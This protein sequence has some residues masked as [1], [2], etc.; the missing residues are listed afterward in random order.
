MRGSLLL[1]L[2]L[3]AAVAL[4]GTAAAKKKGKGRKK[5]P[6]AAEPLKCGVCHAA[7][8]QITEEVTRG[9]RVR[10]TEGQGLG[11]EPH[12]GRERGGDSGGEVEC[13]AGSQKRLRAL[14]ILVESRV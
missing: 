12:S 13:C 14:A 2:L 8:H 9:R 7:V 6:A 11:G 5:A 4:G 1:G 3:L 10:T